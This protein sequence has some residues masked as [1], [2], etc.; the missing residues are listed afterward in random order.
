[1]GN[2]K[3]TNWVSKK[4]YNPRYTIQKMHQKKLLSDNLS[5]AGSHFIG[6]HK[7]TIGSEVPLYEI[8][9][10]HALNQIIGYAKFINRGYGDVYYRGET[11]LHNTLRPSLLRSGNRADSKSASLNV[12]ITKYLTDENFIKLMKLNVD[13][14]YSSEN[15]IEGMLQHYGVPTRYVDVVDN[16]WIALWMGLH[17]CKKYKQ[18]VSYYRYERRAIPYID[19]VKGNEISEDKLYQYVLL[20]AVPGDDRRKNNGIFVSKH[21]MII[22]LR[23]ALPSIF[24]RPHAQHGLI[25]KRCS[26]DAHNCDE[27]DMAD[28][29]IGILKIRV[30]NSHSWLGNGELLS[31]ENLFPP[32]A[33]DNGYDILLQRSDLISASGYEIARYV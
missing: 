33:Y 1:M 32:P 26:K 10:L 13:D 12:L 2:S 5:I 21:Y 11:K 28:S 3:G 31:Q 4:T 14:Q 19:A 24:L 23:Q 6:Y 30:D 25:I 18:M 16:H 9:S 7:F 8:D 27:Y 29:V 22:D 20:L 17:T 15:L